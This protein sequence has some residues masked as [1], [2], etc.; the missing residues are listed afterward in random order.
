MP[1]LRRMRP[2][3]DIA[4]AGLV[5]L[6]VAACS[7]AGPL[8][9]T[10]TITDYL[11]YMAVS[12]GQLGTAQADTAPSPTGGPT[13]VADGFAAAVNGGSAEITVTSTTPFDRVL[14]RLRGVGGHYE[15]PL[16]AP[17]TSATIVFGIAREVSGGG[18][19]LQ[20]A[21]ASGT[22]IGEYVSQSVRVIRVGNGDVQVSI[23][24]KGASDVDLHVTDPS[25]EEVYFG[26]LE[27]ASGG[28]LDLDSNPACRIDGKNNENIVWP[29]NGAPRG[30]YTV[31]VDYYDDCGVAQ[32]DYVVTVLVAGQQPT[33][34]RGSFIGE[35]SNNPSRVFTFTY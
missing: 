25:G 11:P 14:V 20:V 1:S 31:E 6:V 26:N 30:T 18:L 23:A 8:A 32:S 22:A 16:P 5:A 24:W 15:V 27:S 7:E 34:V 21:G 12:T 2:L 19:T 35:S 17:T 9:P 33:V 29:Q 10:N 4:A 13:V 28:R 3:R